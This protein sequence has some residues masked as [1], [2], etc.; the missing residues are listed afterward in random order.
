MFDLSSMISNFARVLIWFLV[1][2]V[3]GII[4]FVIMKILQFKHSILIRGGSVD[5]KDKFRTVKEKDGTVWWRL[6]KR[7]EKIPPA[8]IICQR[9]DKRGKIS[10]TYYDIDGVLIPA[11]P[12]FE[13]T[14]D[15]KEKIIEEFQPYNT[16]ER[17]LIVNQHLKSER[18]KKSSVGEMILKAAP[19]IMLVMILTV[20]MIFFND[21]VQ[22]TQELA[23]KL[24]ES[25]DKE[26]HLTERELDILERSMDVLEG[27][28]TLSG[29]DSEVPN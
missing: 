27:K 10:V 2:A 22:P 29:E 7:K 20:F 25:L 13:M 5:E 12:S 14:E 6:Q 28:Q 23:N 3:V 21:A 16:Q 26:N 1:V 17:A 18:E 15:N 8:P 24:S 19:Y 11:K 4:I 9:H